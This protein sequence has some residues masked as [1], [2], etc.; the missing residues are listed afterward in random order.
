VSAVSALLRRI[1]APGRIV[2]VS[3]WIAILGVGLLAFEGVHPAPDFFGG[4]ATYYELARSMVDAHSYGFD[5]QPATLPPGFPALLAVLC[6]T[7]GCGHALLIRVVII[8]AMLSLL[9]SYEFLRRAQS[10]GM[11]IV[12]CL[13]LAS[14]PQIF[15]LSTTLIFSDLPYFFT[16]LVALMAGAQLAIAR[17]RRARVAWWMVCASFS[18]VSIL[19]R[20]AGITLAIGLAAWLAVS[21][22]TDRAAARGRLWTFLPIVVACL[23]V[24]G[25]WMHWAA[26]HQEVEWPNV[27]GWPKSY[28]AQ[29][30][31]KNGNQPELGPAVLRDIP[32]RIAGN[33]VQRSAGLMGLFTQRDPAYFIPF[34]P[35][36]A[37]LLLV[38]LWSSMGRADGW[39]AWYFAGH[40]AM[41]L[42]WPWDLELRFILPVAPLAF[43]YAVRGG[44]ILAEMAKRRPRVVGMWGLA[45]TAPSAVYGVVASVQSARGHLLLGALACGLT[46]IIA[47]WLTWADSLK[48]P[49]SLRLLQAWTTRAVSI[50]GVV[51]TPL[52]LLG[53]V[54]LAA[55]ATAGVVREVRIG[56]QT[57]SAD[58]TQQLD[59]VAG[60]WLRDHVPTTAV[61]MARQLDVVYHYSR[62]RVVWFPPLSDPQQLMDGI[63]KYN[64]DFIVVTDRQQSYWM[65]SDAVCFERLRDAYPA[66]FALW[67]EQPGLRIFR[68]DRA[69]HPSYP[70]MAYGGALSP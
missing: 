42:L 27:G 48:A 32:V 43:L 17:R 56:Q 18:L 33:A 54:A 47:A 66:S 1:L 36:F 10:R 44:H 46:A 8:F 28:V 41:Y 38:G 63:S 65:P 59:A 31:V 13:L 3:V 29:L 37:G 11:A 35:A 57:P 34:A 51:V 68:V 53:V 22:F 70:S 52:V 5:S 61:I 64:V 55:I 23:L 45:L 4:D 2:D 19:F 15:G 16:S 12:C 9:A 30:A 49:E 58:L 60:Q 62:R 39:A 26:A 14:S 20:S 40:E 21:F 7:V 25:A 50:R 24:Q 67:H 69:R 6:V